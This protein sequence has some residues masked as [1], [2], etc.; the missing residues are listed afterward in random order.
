MSV[1]AVST[2]VIR[3][4]HVLTLKDLTSVLVR[5]HTLEMG[6]PVI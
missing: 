1:P 6:I 5:I 2:L 3:T 4:L